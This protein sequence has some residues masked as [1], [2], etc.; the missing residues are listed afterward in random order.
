MNIGDI[1]K[2]NYPPIRGYKTIARRSYERSELVKLAKSRGMRYLKTGKTQVYLEPRSFNVLALIFEEN[3]QGKMEL[4]DEVKRRILND[5]GFNPKRETRKLR[6]DV[7]SGELSDLA[8]VGEKL[9]DIEE[10]L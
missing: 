7:S 8:E 3:D 4:I 10:H 6:S 9:R 1:P 5:K 2:E